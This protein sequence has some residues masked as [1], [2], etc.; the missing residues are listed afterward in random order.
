MPRARIPYDDLRK[1]LRKKY[2]SPL[3]ANVRL[4]GNTPV[5]VYDR[6]TGN[7]APIGWKVRIYLEQ[8]V[9]IG[10]NSDKFRTLYETRVIEE[11]LFD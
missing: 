8:F 9:G 11:V 7:F 4:D 3:Y 2:P 6:S 1:M 5:R 10:G